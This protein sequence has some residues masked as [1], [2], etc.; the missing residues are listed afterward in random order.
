MV[1]TAND[2]IVKM[3]TWTAAS[4]TALKTLKDLVNECP[5]LFF[6]KKDY[7]AEGT[8]EYEEPIRIYYL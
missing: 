4:R 8:A 7:K 5:K 1:L 2:Q 6:I 3:I